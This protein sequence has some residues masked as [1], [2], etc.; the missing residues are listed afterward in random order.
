MTRAAAATVAF[1]VVGG[2]ASQE[3]SACGDKFLLLG[4]GVRFQRAYAAI[5][6]A[7]ILLVIPPKS[8]KAAAVR[9]SR[10][11][12]ALQMA[13]HRVD[14]VKAARLAEVLAGSR[15]DIILAERADAMGLKNALP[16]AL[17]KPAIVGV[18]EDSRT[19]DETAARLGLDAVLKTPQPLPD[20]LRLLDDVMKARIEKAR[21]AGL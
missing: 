13:G 18:L 8:V 11:K 20:I 9:D 16:A 10:L 3:V 7:A 14:V 4:R 12:T 1:L 21:T 6:P 17:K 19:A 15:Y 5:H 2:L